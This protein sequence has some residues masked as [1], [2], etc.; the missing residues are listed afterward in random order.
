MASIV[1]AI[2]KQ[3]PVSDLLADAFVDNVRYEIMIM[4]TKVH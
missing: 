2:W 1:L 4:Y 3:W